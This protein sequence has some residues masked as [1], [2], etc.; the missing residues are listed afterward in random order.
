MKK[1]TT[2]EFI[3]KA[4][5]VHGDKYDYSKTQYINARTKVIITCPIHGDFEQKPSVHLSNHGCPNCMKN[6]KLNTDSYIQKCKEIHSD[7]Y[8][9]SKTIYKTS[10]DFVTIICPEHGEFKQK[11]YVHLQGHKCPKCSGNNIKRDTA[12]FIIDAN[13]VHNNHYDY[14]KVNYINAQEKVCIICPEHG[15]F[16]QAPK[17][18][19]NRE[20]GCPKC[21]QS[22]GEQLIE[23]LLIKYDLKYKAQFNLVNSYFGQSKLIIDFAVKRNNH[24]YFIEYNGIQHYIPVKYFGGEFKFQ[25]QSRRDQLLRDFCKVHKDQFTLVEIPYSMKDKEIENILKETFGVNGNYQK[26]TKIYQ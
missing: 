11:A 20:Q 1:F 9:Y 5:L 6:R 18:H 7:F 4:R 23:S 17:E 26:T 16:W 19:I 22:K 25:K 24:T 8:D 15:P 10:H 12:Q 2:K 21:S 13:R 14:S 3:E